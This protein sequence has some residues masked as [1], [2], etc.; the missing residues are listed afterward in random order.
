MDEVIKH[1]TKKRFAFRVGD[2]LPKVLRILYYIVLFASF[3]YVIFRFFEWVLV[4]IQ[5]FGEWFFRPQNYWAAVMSIFI[6]LVGAFLIAQFVLGLDPID[7]VRD[8]LDAL[9]TRLESRYI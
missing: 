4:N 1:V 3:V 9:F 7:Q 2:R 6:L 5:R 8:W